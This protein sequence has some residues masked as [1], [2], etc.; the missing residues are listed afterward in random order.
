[1]K[2][3]IEANSVDAVKTVTSDAE[4]EKCYVKVETE[5]STIVA[6]KKV[7]VNADLI[8]QLEKEYG[9]PD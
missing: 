7:D 6:T 1:M 5:D 4:V 9:M 8:A 3:C 2:I